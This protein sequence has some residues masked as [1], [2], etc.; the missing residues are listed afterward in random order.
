MP[1]ILI[2]KIKNLKIK[3]KLLC[4]PKNLA[5]LSSMSPDSLQWNF[6]LQLPSFITDLP[7]LFHENC[8]W[9]QCKTELTFKLAPSPHASQLPITF[10]LKCTWNF[11]FKM[12]AKVEIASFFLS[13]LSHNS[14]KSQGK[15]NSL[16]L[17]LKRTFGER[18]GL[19]T[20]PLFHVK[21]ILKYFRSFN[22][23]TCW[24]HQI[25]NIR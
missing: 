21:P 18:D 14:D 17:E 23:S 8:S 2:H 5:P 12:H 25:L 9:T 4:W 22:L 3:T 20:A 15:T 6:S 13:R 7:L 24:M 10:K 19:L 16:F 1:H 11:N